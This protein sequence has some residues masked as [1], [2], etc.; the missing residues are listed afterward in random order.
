MGKADQLEIFFALSVRPFSLILCLFFAFLIVFTPSSSVALLLLLLLFL[1]SPFKFST[2]SFFSCFLPF[3]S[4][5]NI[6]N[7]EHT[8]QARCILTTLYNPPL[9]ETRRD[10]NL[11]IGIPSVF[12]LSLSILFCFVSSLSI[13]SLLTWRSETFR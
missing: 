5:S 11:Y 13:S 4:L 2:P 12:S 9:I 6:S 10:Y 3:L 1:S 8:T 7:L